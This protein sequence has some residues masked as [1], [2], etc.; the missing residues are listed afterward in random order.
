MSNNDIARLKELTIYFTKRELKNRV[1]GNIGGYFW[2][3]AQP[4]LTVLMFVFIFSII[5]KIRVQ[6]YYPEA[7]SFTVFLLSGLLPWM[8]FQESIL[9]SMTVILENAEAIKKI[10]FPTESLVMGTGLACYIITGVGFS[11]LVFYCCLVLNFVSV[12]LS[13]IKIFL[14]FSL[15]AAQLLLSIGIGFIA[16]ALTVYLRDLIQIIPLLMQIWFYTTPIVYPLEMV[17]KGIKKFILMNPMT[18]YVELYRSIL[19]KKT[20]PP[21]EQIIPLLILIIVCLAIGIWSFTKLKEGFA[22]VL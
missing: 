20:L 9:R 14:T 16:S 10:P 3:I 21:A 8:A 18:R 6:N 11:I 17:P 1:A 12:K 15:Y 4:L 22:D 7:G 19:L 5:L 13:L 2:I